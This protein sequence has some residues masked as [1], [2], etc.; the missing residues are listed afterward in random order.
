MSA[1]LVSDKL[2]SYTG[3]QF[4]SSRHGFP[5]TI[6]TEQAILGVRI[7]IQEAKDWL[8]FGDFNAHPKPA[9]LDK[10]HALGSSGV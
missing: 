9:I 5:D 6:H 8:V 10:V 1:Q 7:K 4:S 2:N 3:G